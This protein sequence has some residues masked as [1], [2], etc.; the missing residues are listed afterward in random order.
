MNRL[1]PVAVLFALATPALA[2]EYQHGMPPP[3]AH[4]R[5][6]VPPPAPTPPP[7]PQTPGEIITTTFGPSAGIAARPAAV[8]GYIVK[9]ATAI[10]SF[11]SVTLPA[12]P[13]QPTPPTATSVF[14]IGSITKGFTGLI[15]ADMVLNGEV[16]LTDTLE[17]LLPEGA[18]YP[19]AVR[20][21]TLLQLATQSSGLPR[22]PGNLSFGMKDPA[23]PYAHYSPKE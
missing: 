15:L 23:N 6:Q 22:L 21:V 14:E 18:T 1:L 5:P 7:R 12:Q 16:A 2:Q 11:G 17:K 9:G 8:V 3:P 13:A 19:E 20:A 4:Q 10:K